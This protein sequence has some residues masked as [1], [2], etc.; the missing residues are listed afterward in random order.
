VLNGVITPHGWKNHH[1]LWKEQV[2]QPIQCN[3]VH[4]ALK[5]PWRSPHVENIKGPTSGEEVGFPL[6]PPLPLHSRLFTMSDTKNSSD[7]RIDDVEKHQVS[8]SEVPLDAHYDP[9]FVS[10]TLYVF[11]SSSKNL[12]KH[13]AAG[14][15]WIGECFLY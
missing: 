8:I 2:S 6:P 15:W 5:I 1:P 14:E 9:K 7:L 3:Y 10:R 4:L 12:A 11:A 13:V